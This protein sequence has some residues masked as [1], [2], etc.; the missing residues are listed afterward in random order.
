M[1]LA[2]IHKDMLSTT[3][4]LD[5]VTRARGRVVRQLYCPF[6]QVWFNPPKFTRIKEDLFRFVRV[7]P[8]WQSNEMHNAY[9]GNGIHGR[10]AE[11]EDLPARVAEFCIMAEDSAQLARLEVT[12]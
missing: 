12:W 11:L 1:R 8:N 2:A 4:K 5:E 3:Y 10:I 7:Y 6:E 9:Y